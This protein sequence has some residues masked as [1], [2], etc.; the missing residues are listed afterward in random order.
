MNEKLLNSSKHCETANITR[1]VE[2]TKNSSAFAGFAGKIL[3][4]CLCISL[5]FALT[6]CKFFFIQDGQ[7]QNPDNAE[8]KSNDS[9]DKTASKHTHT[10]AEAVIE[11]YTESTCTQFGSW[12]EVV[13]C[14]D[15]KSV[16]SKNYVTSSPTH[17]FEDGICEICK[18]LSSS[19]GLE[20]ILNSDEKSYTVVGI[21]NCKSNMIVIDLYNNLPVTSI[22]DEAFIGCTNLVSVT[23]GNNVRSIGEK[24]FLNCKKLVEICNLSDLSIVCEAEENGYAGKYALNVYSNNIGKSNLTTVENDFVFYKD[25][26]FCYLVAYNGKEAI[27]SLPESCNGEDYSVY[28]YAFY[29]YKSLIKLTIPEGVTYIGDAAFKWCQKLVEIYNFSSLSINKYG[30]ENGFV[31]N[32]AHHIY[33]SADQE[34]CVVVENEYVFWESDSVS[35]LLG[36]IGDQTDLILPELS[37]NGNPYGVYLYAFADCSEITSI[38][39]SENINY[40]YP[41]AFIGC[42][43]LNF[44]EFDGILYLGT[45]SNPYFAAVDAADKS[46]ASYEFHSDT[47]LMCMDFGNDY[48]EIVNISIPNDIKFIVGANVVSSVYSNSLIYNY[49]DGSIYLGNEDNPY[50]ILIRGNTGSST[51]EIHPRTKYI[52]NN[53]FANLTKLTSIDIPDSVVTIGN[54][55]FQGCTSLK[56]VTLGSGLISIGYLAFRNCN[57][58]VDITFK[59]TSD[60]Y[61]TWNPASLTG[62]PVLS[63][64]ALI[65]LFKSSNGYLIRVANQDS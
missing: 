27:L 17:S 12:N 56:S 52:Q 24:A 40:I 49:Y 20:F 32:N 2:I 15:C 42:E 1:C 51:C 39:L 62:D 41:Q 60:W 9:N 45:N 47:N 30:T 57:S 23:V 63:Q 36:Y 35:L 22:A 58:L 48:T 21:G 65:S 25:N 61:Y 64:D 50:L 28:D 34:G 7:G 26:H 19:E 33:T 59:N 8:D 4:L 18:G 46:L 43:K 31:A 44:N 38:I 11:D 14:S 37:P 16:I 3:F 6:A 55:A 5:V 13:Y 29:G 54:S 53:A 10:P